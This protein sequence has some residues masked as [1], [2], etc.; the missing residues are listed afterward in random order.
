MKLAEEKKVVLVASSLNLAT[1]ATQV[2]KGINMARY[3][4]CTFLIDVGTMSGSNSTLKAYSGATDIALTSAIAFKYAYGG[5]SS[6]WLN[7]AVSVP[8]T[9]AV[10][11][12]VLAAETTVTAATG[13][14]IL[15]ATYPNYMLIVEVDASMMDVAN[16]ENWLSLEFT[17]ASSSAGLVTVFAIL[18]PRYTS[19]L[20]ATALA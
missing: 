1:D 20:S 15:Q 14:V 19:N 12:D 10:T 11:A 5:S 2:T 4:K 6:I 16:G 3:H 13:L 17:D 7:G 18:E 8:A 9:P